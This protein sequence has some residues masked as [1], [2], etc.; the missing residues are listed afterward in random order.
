[1]LGAIV[2]LA[3]VVLADNETDD[4]IYDGVEFI[5]PEAG[6]WYSGDVDVEWE[7]EFSFAPLFLMIQA[8][9]CE[10]SGDWSLVL[11]DIPFSQVV[12]PWDTNVVDDGEYC[13]RLSSSDE[14][15]DTGLFCVDNEE[16]EVSACSGCFGDTGIENDEFDEET[17]SGIRFQ[18][19][20][21]SLEEE[22]ACEDCEYECELD[23]GDGSDPVDCFES[24][25]CHFVDGQGSTQEVECHHQYGDNGV[26]DV[27]VTI[28]DCA[29][30]D[31]DAEVE[32][33]VE[34]VDPVCE[35]I[36]APSEVVVGQPVEFSAEAYDVDADMPLMFDWDFDDGD[37]GTGNPIV[38]IY[39]TEGEYT[40]SLMVSDK[41]GGYDS[42]TH[43]IEAV[44][45]IVLDDQE[46]AAY[47]PLK[48]DFGDDAGTTYG[49]RGSFVTGLEGMSH[50]DCDVIVGPENLV[51]ASLADGECTVVWDNDEIAHPMISENPTNDEQ[52]DHLVIIKA[53][54]GEGDYE[55]FTFYVTVYSWIIELEEGWNLVSIPYVPEDVSIESVILDQLGGEG[56]DILPGGTEYVVWSYQYSPCEECGEASRWLKSRRSGYGDLD[57]VVPGYGY[58]IKTNGE[59]KLRGFGT[60]IAQTG[61]FPGMPPEVELP[62]N[63]WSLIGRYGILGD[64]WY[65]YPG[66]TCWDAGAISK[67][68]ALESLSKED[69]QLHLFTVTEDAH[70]DEVYKLWNNEGYW[71]WIEDEFEGNTE[72]E[73]YAP[74]DRFYREDLHCGYPCKDIC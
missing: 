66:E 35:G 58:W 1:M 36:D 73:T 62:T 38:H 27:M 34:N 14:F 3:G 25:Y 64:D 4:P 17:A 18:F 44:E 68:T 43:E 63:S 24:R 45:P 49:H 13:L 55:Y 47:Y 51:S 72:S 23:W 48:A 65:H 42:C 46:V 21:N 59:G 7:N 8:D 30:N 12:F 41:D 61:E 50:T 37:Y 57:S 11:G 10:P 6:E 56:Q 2:L 39:E 60:Q 53:M 15:V 19:S 29:G 67:M 74:L 32:V 54:N 33:F 70:L 52:G 31:G 71:L 16:P 22:T 20:D 9:S 28:T 69:N 26:Y 40:V 5:T